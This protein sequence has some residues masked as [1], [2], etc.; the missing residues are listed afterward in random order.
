M[1]ESIPSKVDTATITALSPEG[2]GKTPGTN[3]VSAGTEGEGGGREKGPW[4][5]NQRCALQLILANPVFLQLGEEE[6]RIGIDKVTQAPDSMTRL[7]CL[8]KYLQGVYFT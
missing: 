1:P 6:G 5:G 2:E 7:N 8:T 4:V 3:P